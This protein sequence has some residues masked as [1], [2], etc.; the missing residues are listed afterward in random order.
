MNIVDLVIMVLIALGAVTGY[1]RGLIESLAGLFSNI[2]GFFVALKYYSSLILWANT[3]LDMKLSLQTYFQK[4]LILPAP[5]MQLKLEKVPLPEIGNYL[6]K[7]NLPVI[8]KAQLAQYIQSLE[9]G[10]LTQAVLG[11]VIYQ[12]LANAI[13]NAGA[14]ILIWLSVNILIM[15]IV[16]MVRSITNN[17][18]IAS[19]DHGA[20]LLIGTALTAFTLTI[21]IGLVSPLLQ[22]TN[23]A[24]P[25]L[26][27]AVFK[28]MGESRLLPY[29][30]N[31]FNLLTDKIAAFWL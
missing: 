31:T 7:I 8:L 18:V 2:I 5:L 25:T 6:D 4:H 26:F 13:I 20:G 9:V 10:M 28:T 14:F 19:F 24:E 1:R 23:L 17:T 22:V 29:F 21:V 16:G 30:L 12:Y 15:L 3:Y 11:D 27:S